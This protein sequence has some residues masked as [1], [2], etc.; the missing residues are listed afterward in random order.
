MSKKVLLVTAGGSG[1]GAA[2]ARTLAG[3]DY[4]VGILSSSGRGEALAKELGRGRGGHGVKS[5]C[6]GFRRPRDANHAALWAH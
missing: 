1:M 4:N 6:G 3:R 2:I 5:Q